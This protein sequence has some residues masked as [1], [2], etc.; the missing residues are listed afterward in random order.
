M[1]KGRRKMS[2]RNQS[3]VRAADLRGAGDLPRTLCQARFGERSRLWNF[4]RARIQ[5]AL[6]E[7]SSLVPRPAS[8]V[9]RLR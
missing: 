4:D 8:T 3:E 2:C 1:P 9:R 6:P 7:A 5:R